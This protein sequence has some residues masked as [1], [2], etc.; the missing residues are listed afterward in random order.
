MTKLAIGTFGTGAG[1]VAARAGTAL[2][3]TIANNGPTFSTA[4]LGTAVATG[5][6]TIHQPFTVAVS[7]FS[8]AHNPAWFGGLKVYK[9]AHNNNTSIVA[10]GELKP[11]PDSVT[12]TNAVDLGAGSTTWDIG[13]SYVAG[14]GRESVLVWPAA[15]SAIDVGKIL[16]IGANSV[17]WATMKG[18]TSGDTTTAVADA[19]NVRFTHPAMSTQTQATVQSSA[20]ANGSYITHNSVNQEQVNGMTGTGSVNLDGMPDGSTYAK[21]LATALTSGQVDLSKAGVISKTMDNITDTTS[22]S[23]V[24][25]TE[26]AGSA[27]AHTVKQLN[28]G[29]YTRTASNV[30][31]V[32]NTSGQLPNS[33]PIIALTPNTVAYVTDATIEYSYTGTGPYAVS[34]WYDNGTAATDASVL[35]PDGTSLNLGHTTSAS[36]SYSNASVPASTNFYVVLHYSGGTTTMTVQTTPF[37]LSQFASYFADGGIIPASAQAGTPLFTASGSGGSGSKQGGGGGHVPTQ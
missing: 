23:A 27:G 28:D 19:S 15:F 33:T 7:D 1:P 30:A 14:N 8:T 5:A 13:F 11:Q 37:T 32:V 2:P 34:I 17:T 9:R 6:A 20:D 3:S 16:E 29:T 21:P 10:I 18:D 36:P 24:L 12:W 31:A 25:T 26:L 22:R 35:Y 4:T